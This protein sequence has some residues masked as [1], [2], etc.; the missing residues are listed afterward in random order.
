[1][2]S[3]ISKTTTNLVILFLGISLVMSSCQKED[4]EPA[5]VA[6]ADGPIKDKEVVI[7]P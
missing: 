7:L 4:V 2:K 6:N 5:P 3:L 1:M